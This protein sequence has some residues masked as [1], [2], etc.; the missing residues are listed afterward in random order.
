MHWITH[1]SI[2]VSR[3]LLSIQAYLNNTG[4]CMISILPLISNSP[5]LLSSL[6]G[7]VPS[8]STTICI[9]IN[10]MFYIFFRYLLYPVND[11]TMD[12]IT[13]N[14]FRHKYRSYQG[15]LGSSV[16]STEKD[17]DTRLTKAWTAI[18]RLAVIWKSDLTDKMKRSFFQKYC[19]MDALHER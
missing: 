7:A 12:K 6:L 10:F 2:H 15:I 14:D 4:I 5:S 17:I 1:M 9:P 11:T 16:S 18:D 3:T 13:T 8:T 19:Y